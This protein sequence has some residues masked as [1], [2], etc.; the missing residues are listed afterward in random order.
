MEFAEIGK[1]KLQRLKSWQA[2]LQ[3]YWKCISTLTAL[4][5][6]FEDSGVSSLIYTPRK[7]HYV[8]NDLYHLWLLNKKISLWRLL[9]QNA[10]ETEPKT[11]EKKAG[12]Q[13]AALKKFIQGRDGFF[14]KSWY[15][16]KFAG[17]LAELMNL[18][19]T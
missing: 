3:W 4:H 8:P 18:E 7:A 14:E 10:I 16:G 5:F 2:V 12:R 17:T 15:P 11:W 6:S 9:G 19:K 1:K 13:Q